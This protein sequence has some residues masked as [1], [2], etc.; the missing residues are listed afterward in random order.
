MFPR[1]C[2]H[3]CNP[4]IPIVFPTS[5]KSGCIERIILAIT[6]SGI[7]AFSM[8]LCTGIARRRSFTNL[9][10]GRI[11][12]NYFSQFLF[13]CYAKPKSAGNTDSKS[14]CASKASYKSAD[15]KPQVDCD[16]LCSFGKEWSLW[17]FIDQGG[18]KRSL[19][20]LLRSGLVSQS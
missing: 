8:F 4:S 7:E 5:I 15:I 16:I 17:G 6:D 9:W 3:P 2:R 14:K 13:D 12:G 20:N 18:K 11:P 19:E 10:I 1:Y